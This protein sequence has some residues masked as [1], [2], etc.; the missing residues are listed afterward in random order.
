MLGLL[1]EKLGMTQIF[2]VTGTVVPVTV[3]KAGPCTV[4][5]KKTAQ[6]DGYQAIQVGFDEI[7]AKKRN[8]PYGGHFIKKGQKVYRF[9]REMRT[10]HA[11]AYQ[12]GETLTVADF[13]VG[14]WVDVAG[15]SKGKGFQGVMKRHHFAGGNDS[16]GC[17]ISHRSA[18]AIGQRT[19]PGKVFKGKK[20]AGRM[21]GEKVTVKNLRVVAVEPQNNLLLVGGAIPG[22]NHGLISVTTRSGDFEKRVLAKKIKK[23]TA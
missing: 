3:L 1:A 14:D 12:P 2:G 23:E 20:M 9:L 18:G 21:G 16:H 17:S 5:M 10:E 7:E 13:E 6:K 19:Y 11:D 15:V 22:A 8:K 4:V